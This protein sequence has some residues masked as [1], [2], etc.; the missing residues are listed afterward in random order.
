MNLREGVACGF[1]VMRLGIDAGIAVVSMALAVP[2][3]FAIGE[4]AAMAREAR[5]RTLPV[6]TPTDPKAH[7]FGTIVTHR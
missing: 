2:V 3:G 5:G 1:S 4:G 6:T 7:D